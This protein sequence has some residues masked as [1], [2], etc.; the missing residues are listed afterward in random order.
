MYLNHLNINLHPF[1]LF[2]QFKIFF[3]DLIVVEHSLQF[4][5]GPTIT[6]QKYE[7]VN[8]NTYSKFKSTQ[9]DF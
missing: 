4:F 6:K 9:F 5:L 1:N 3:S 8:T 7:T 2:N